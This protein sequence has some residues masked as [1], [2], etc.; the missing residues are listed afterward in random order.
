[1][2]AGVAELFVAPHHALDACTQRIGRARELR[3]RS[4]HGV[5]LIEQTEA[6]GEHLFGQELVGMASLPEGRDHLCVLIEI[7]RARA[8][9]QGSRDREGHDQKEARER[10]GAPTLGGAHP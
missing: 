1:V 2:I 8:Q 5:I 4:V 6:R 9:V 3:L 7:H 10:E